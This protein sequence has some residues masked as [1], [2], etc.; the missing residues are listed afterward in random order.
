MKVKVLGTAQDGGVPQIACYC[1]TCNHAREEPKDARLGP[2]LGIFDPLKGSIYIIDASPN[3]PQQLDMLWKET[4][5]IREKGKFP[6]DG[7][8]LTHGHFGHI[9]GLGYLG[10]EACSPKE[11]PLYCTRDMAEYLR[12]NRPFAD[13]VQRRNV[14]INEIK[15]GTPIKLSQNTFITPMKV[16]HRQDVAD[17]VGFIIS[18]EKNKLL[19]I[20]DMDDYTDD[21]IKA[22]GASNIAILDGCFYSTDELPHRNIK[23]IPHPFIPYSMEKLAHLVGKTQIYFTHFNHTNYLLRLRSKEKEDLIA[24]GF[25]MAN[26]GD[27]FIV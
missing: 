6:L 23:E 21:I 9:W 10:K 26:D 2:S 11:L 27:E 16:P 7:I 25:M 15:P 13:L 1:Q 4:M 12:K 3:L 17:T 18:G 24:R 8:F 22:I 20:P 5:G 19:Y 14:I